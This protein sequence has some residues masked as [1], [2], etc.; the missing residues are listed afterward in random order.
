[1]PRIVQKIDEIAKNLRITF[2][3]AEGKTTEE[4]TEYQSNIEN[5]KDFLKDKKPLH[6]MIEDM[7][8]QIEKAKTLL[9]K[10]RE[11]KSE[12]KFD[13]S[14]LN[15]EIDQSIEL[16]GNNFILGSLRPY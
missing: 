14:V 11:L 3:I 1:M 10:S 7:S 15:D 8:M 6:K 12:L 2:A 5:I 4:I 13:I 16:I 9:S